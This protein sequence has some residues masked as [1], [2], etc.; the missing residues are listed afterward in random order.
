M[1]ELHKHLRS[2]QSTQEFS[3]IFS[4]FFLENLT[5]Q[6]QTNKKTSPLPPN[7]PKK[8]RKGKKKNN[9]EQKIIILPHLPPI[10]QPT[11]PT[12]T[13]PTTQPTN[14]PTTQATNRGM[15]NAQK[16]IISGYGSGPKG[17]SK[18]DSVGFVGW[19]RHQDDVGVV[20][21]FGNAGFWNWGGVYIYIYIFLIENYCRWWFQTFFIFTPIWRNHQLENQ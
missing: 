7:P 16:G 13:Q 3:R 4:M 6:K 12:T 20:G 21:G 14:N 11:Q 9:N 1:S 8:Q 19:S 5:V 18:G 17:A 15:V 10:N 2:M